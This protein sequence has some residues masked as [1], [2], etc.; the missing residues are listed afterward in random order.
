MPAGRPSEYNDKILE[1]AKKYITSCRDSKDEVNIPTIEGLSLYL[2]I[3]RETVY[4]WKSKYDEFSDIVVAVMSE[5][6]KRLINKGLSGTYNSTIAKLLLSKH[7]YKEQIGLSG[8]GEGDPI[9]IETN[10]TD[11]IDQVYG[12]SDPSS[13]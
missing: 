12:K 4:D 10:V 7:G 9:K 8:E 13:S 2:G 11:T 5:Q 3:T 6:G 1:K